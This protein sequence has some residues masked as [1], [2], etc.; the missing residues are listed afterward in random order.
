MHQ[1]AQPGSS[2]SAM[3][4]PLPTPMPLVSGCVERA[5]FPPALVVARRI[6]TC[7]KIFSAWRGIYRSNGIQAVLQPEQSPAVQGF[8]VFGCNCA[9]SGG[10][11]Q[12]RHRS[13]MLIRSVLVRFGS[14]YSS[15]H[16][17]SVTF[18]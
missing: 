11:K 16:P 4:L 13:F 9:G 18:L 17:F 7:R 8:V 10:Q 5:L 14:G 1:S 12:A 6:F 15:L 3:R 2:I